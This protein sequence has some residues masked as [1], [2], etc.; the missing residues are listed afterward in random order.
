MATQIKQLAEIREKIDRDKEVAPVSV[1]DF[2]E[3]F[4]VQRRGSFIVWWIRRELDKA[5]LKTEPDFQSA[6]IDSAITF[7]S[8]PA[9]GEEQGEDDDSGDDIHSE[10]DIA[11]STVLAGSTDPTYRIS[12]LAAA[13][14]APISVNPTTTKR[15][16]VTL[17]LANDFSQLPVMTTEREV[18]GVI[19]WASIGARLALGKDGEHVH[20][21]MDAHF[22]IRADASIFQAIPTLVEHDYVLVRGQ[23][24]RITGIVTSADLSLQFRQLAE[25]FLLLGE[26][27]NHIRLLLVDKFSDKELA[28][29]RDPSDAGRE[30]TTVADLTFGEYIRLLEHD[31]RFER[32]RMPVDRKTFCKQLDEVRRIRNDVTHFDPDG[33]PPADLNRLREFS[34]FL[35]RLKTIGVS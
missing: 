11:N 12:K 2:L 6:Y 30:V 20:E 16:A 21:L 25:P 34:G 22:E 24:N 17:M 14:N 26:I 31:D 9:P 5:G 29:I 23:D 7:I 27:E 35:Q 1:R 13:N 3:W 19:S 32:T 15:E 28:A 18:K 10:G 4:G 8:A 33:I